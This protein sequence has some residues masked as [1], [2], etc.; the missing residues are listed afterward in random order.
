MFYSAH[1]KLSLDHCMALLVVFIIGNVLCSYPSYVQRH[2]M[3]MNLSWMYVCI[4]IY[5]NESMRS[6]N[7]KHDLY[8]QANFFLKYGERCYRAVQ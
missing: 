4:I 5:A 1:V 2:C 7:G 6:S 8:V 3:Q